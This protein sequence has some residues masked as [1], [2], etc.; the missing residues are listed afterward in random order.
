MTYNVQKGD[1]IACVTKHLQT[2]WQTLKNQNPEAVGRSKKNGHWFLREGA[3]VKVDQGRFSSLLA[4]ATKKN[5]SPDQ[6][7]S[8]E[9]S[10]DVVT[11]TVKPG[12][13]L[14]GLA[15]G[16][17]HVNL[18]QMAEDN[19]IENPDLIQVGQQLKIKRSHPQ[20]PSQVVASWYGKDF[21][22]KPMANGQPYDMY[23]DTIAHKKLPLGTKVEL[24]NPRTGQTITA[25]VTDRGPYVT[26]RDVDLSYGVAR[27]LSMVD[28]GV[29][30][31]I[32]KVL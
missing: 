4:E 17:F 12:D 20:P 15:V 27:K 32:M 24:N 5:G 1:T 14:W 21:Q 22:G 28:D 11:Y 3:T 29:D 2:D 7:K 23:A 13:T 8:S 10:S 26:G 31:L 6:A 19:G 18:Q 25:V 30:T 16:K 9:S